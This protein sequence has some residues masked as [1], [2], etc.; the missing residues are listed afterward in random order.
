[1]VNLACIFGIYNL[2]VPMCLQPPNSVL[3]HVTNPCNFLPTCV[4]QRSCAAGKKVFLR[5][6]VCGLAHSLSGLVH[7]IQ[8]F[9]GLGRRGVHFESP[10]CLVV[11]VFGISAITSVDS[12]KF[13]GL[14][15]ISYLYGGFP[16]CYTFMAGLS[17]CRKRG[18]E[19]VDSTATKVAP[20]F[21]LRSGKRWSMPGC[22]ALR[23][24]SFAIFY[25]V[26]LCQLRRPAWAVVSSIIPWEIRFY[27]KK[28]A[29]I[30]PGMLLAPQLCYLG[31]VYKPGTHTGGNCIKI[32]LPGKLILS[33]R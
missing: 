2:Y 20:A 3:A 8:Q 5:Y 1:M 16:C 17:F 21:Q 15:G 10:P 27:Y 22:T 7:L 26:F 18:R 30:F 24:T 11:P 23:I 32:G 12:R 28:L 19:S 4:D 13:R 25:Y 9:C 6:F 14:G 31:S 33:K 29:G